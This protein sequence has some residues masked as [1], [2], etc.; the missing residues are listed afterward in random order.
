MPGAPWEQE[1][2]QWA[3]DGRALRDCGRRIAPH[4][5]AVAAALHVT[6]RAL[7]LLDRRTQGLR[8]RGQKQHEERERCDGCPQH[9]L[10]LHDCPIADHAGDLDHTGRESDPAGSGGQ[11]GQQPDRIRDPRWWAGMTRG[12]RD[13]ALAQE[14]AAAS[15]RNRAHIRFGRPPRRRAESRAPTLRPSP[16]PL[17]GASAPRSTMPPASPPRCRGRP[18]EL[19]RRCSRTPPVECHAARGR[20]RAAARQ[21]VPH[22]LACTSPN[23]Q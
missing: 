9:G 22:R 23:P 19:A 12:R 18:R 20:T 17:P 5:H 3:C 16:H 7:R 11:P 13:H 4:R 2:T 15:R 10:S 6:Q 1:A 8:G 14:R 21:N